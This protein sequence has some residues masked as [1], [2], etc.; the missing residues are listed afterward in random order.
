MGIKMKVSRRVF[1]QTKEMKKQLFKVYRKEETQMA[2]PAS[3]RGI[4]PM[5]Y[6][7]PQS[8]H[9]VAGTEA[10]LTFVGASSR[11]FLTAAG[12]N[13]HFMPYTAWGSDSG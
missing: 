7:F 12:A 8:T 9:T 5:A 4:Q 1:R 6:K 3:H 2:H 11:S 13:T 10:R